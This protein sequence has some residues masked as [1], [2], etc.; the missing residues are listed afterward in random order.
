MDLILYEDNF[1]LIFELVLRY[2]KTIDNSESMKLCGLIILTSKNIM[3]RFIN[4]DFSCISFDIDIIHSC[5][6][7]SL[8][9]FHY[10]ISLRKFV[11]STSLS[12][13]AKI[14]KLITLFEK[15]KINYYMDSQIANNTIFDI[16]IKPIF[17]NCNTVNISYQNINEKLIKEKLADI[18][19]YE[20]I[21]IF[22]DGLTPSVLFPK[23]CKNLMIT[24]YGYS[25]INILPNDTFKYDK[26]IITFK[27]YGKMGRKINFKNF[28]NLQELEINGHMTIIN[29]LPIT[30]KKLKIIDIDYDFSKL[31]NLT[32]LS[33]ILDS[34]VEITNIPSNIINLEII[35]RYHAFPKLQCKKISNLNLI[36]HLIL[37]NDSYNNVT[38][39]GSKFDKVVDLKT[40][41]IN[42][43]NLPLKY[44]IH[45][46]PYETTHYELKSV[47]DTK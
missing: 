22:L 30:L 34:T 9:K 27:I 43:I 29:N 3:N 7:I 38:V 40:K 32:H 39:D 1:L 5:D 21:N 44:N 6:S 25:N 23:K 11:G 13:W 42:L 41:G 19:N 28:E 14:N 17:K 33:L 37:I 2:L 4:C 45:Y 47:D 35:W 8:S 20:S 24:V 15:D 46:F 12:K 26:L 10:L 18:D 16:M 31:I 36:K